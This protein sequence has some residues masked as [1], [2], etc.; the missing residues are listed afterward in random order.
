MPRHNWAS[1]EGVT[2]NKMPKLSSTLGMDLANLSALQDGMGTVGPV[3]P[4]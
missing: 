1:I 4:L 3:A 2:V